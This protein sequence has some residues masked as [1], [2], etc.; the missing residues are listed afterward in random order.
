VRLMNI[1]AEELYVN[2]FDLEHGTSR[3]EY[4]LQQGEDVPLPHLIAFRISKEEVLY[5]WFL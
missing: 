3:V 2:R 4:K 1:I 5:N